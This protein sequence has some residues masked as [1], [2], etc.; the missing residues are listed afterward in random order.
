VYQNQY[1]ACNGSL[2][3]YWESMRSRTTL[4]ACANHRPLL[5]EPRAGG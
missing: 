1:K 5:A 3:P 4:A 2:R